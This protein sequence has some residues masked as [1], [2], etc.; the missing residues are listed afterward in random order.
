MRHEG[1]FYIVDEKKDG[2]YGDWK[3]NVTAYEPINYVFYKGAFFGLNFEVDRYIF[4]DWI[5]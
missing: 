5:V 2:D 3:G 1:C 4:V